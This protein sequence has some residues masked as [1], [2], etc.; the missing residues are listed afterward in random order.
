LKPIGLA[1]GPVISLAIGLA[2]APVAVAA[3]QPFSLDD[4]W[5]FRAACDPRIS[6]D[7]SRVVYVE[8]WNDRDRDAFGS[9]LWTVAADGATRPRQLTRGPWRDFSPRWSP[10]GARLAY[11]SDRS[12]KTQ[13]RVHTVDSGQEL[14]IPTALPPEALAW[15]ADGKWLAFTAPVPVTATLP[16]WAPPALLPL[17]QQRVTSRVRIFVVGSQGGAPR[18]LT[19][20]DFHGDL[21]GDLHGDLNYTGEPAWMPDGREILAAAAPVADAGNPLQGG[22]IYAIR[23][24]DGARRQLTQHRGSEPGGHVQPESPM[25]SPDG[26]KIAWVA[27]EALPQSYTIRKLYV[28]N[29]DGSRVKV[30]AGALDRDVR[31]P[32]WSSDSRTVYFLADDHGATYVYAARNDGSVRQAT[33]EPQRLGGFSLADNGRAVAVRSTATAADEVVA[34]PVDLAG[35]PARLA[36]PAEGLLAARDTGRAEEVHWASDGKTIQGWVLKPPGFDAAKKYPLLLDIDE[37]PGPKS[38]RRMCGPEFRLR[39]QLFAAL[40]YVVLCANPRGTPGYGEEFGNL[41]HSRYP[42]DDFDDL[43]RGVDAVAAKGYVDP[44]RLTLVGGLLAAWAIGHTDRFAA[45]VARRPIADWVTH[46]AL[47]PDGAARAAAWMGAMPWENPEQYTKHSPLF[48][49]QSFQTPTLVIAGE[50]D[51]ESEELYFALQA[52]KVES[53]LVRMRGEVTPGQVLLELEATMGW[54]GRFVAG[55]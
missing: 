17:L 24:A 49:A 31:R 7:G 40:G 19:A 35:Q 14:E 29:A 36:A 2:C 12:G 6:G 42:G 55:R 8:T 13:I 39:A 11:L 54:L 25:A 30:L 5:A 47:T 16:A 45:V 38:S 43:I 33:R 15:S 51:P 41:I 21:N 18:Q 28:M 32:Q 37:A 52:R 10:D 44:K 48:W 27:R 3:S 46:V 50:R 9:N 20:G 26:S 34:F 1:I 23:V 4:W 22:E 53:A